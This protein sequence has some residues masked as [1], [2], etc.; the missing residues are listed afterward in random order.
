MIQFGK[1][2]SK[3]LMMFPL[4]V[5]FGLNY[6][7]VS[8]SIVFSASTIQLLLTKSEALFLSMPLATNKSK[9]RFIS[10]RSDVVKP[11]VLLSAN[12]L[13]SW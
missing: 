6:F 13:I 12:I 1:E 7:L 2:Q 3:R 5:Y 8:E 4:V 10:D 11:Q 9:A